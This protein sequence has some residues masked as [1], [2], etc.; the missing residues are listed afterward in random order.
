MLKLI[1]TL[2]CGLV[3]S[4]PFWTWGQQNLVRNSSFEK[5]TRSPLPEYNGQLE[6]K[7]DRWKGFAGT[8]SDWFKNPGLFSGAE[9][10][11]LTAGAPGDPSNSSDPGAP[12]IPPNSGRAYAGLIKWNSTFGEGVQQRLSRKLDPGPHALSFFYFLPCDTNSYGIRAYLGASENDTSFLIVQDTLDRN[13]TGSWIQFSTNFSLSPSQTDFDWLSIVNTGESNPSGGLG[14][15]IYLDDIFL[16][17]SNCTACDPQGLISYNQNVPTTFS[18]DGDGIYDTLYVENINNVS[19]Y[20]M[21]IFD[22][23]GARLWD[24]S[25]FRPGGFENLILKWDGTDQSSGLPVTADVVQLLVHLENCNSSRDILRTVNVCHPNSF[26]SPLKWDTIPNY[27]APLF[28]MELPPTHYGSLDV[29]GG[30]WYGTHHWFACD[31]IRVGA[32]ESKITPYFWAASTSNL[33]FSASQSIEIVQGDSIEIDPGAVVEFTIEPV[34]C[35]ASV[36]LGGAGTT[37]SEA[38][39]TMPVSSTSLREKTS[40]GQFPGPSR[41]HLFPNPTPGMITINCPNEL[42]GSVT[43]TITNSKGQIIQYSQV[44]S[45][46]TIQLDLSKFPCGIYWLQLETRWGRWN[47]KLILQ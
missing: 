33:E 15:Y 18:P 29:Y 41:F 27:V 47:Q 9:D 6:Q 7:C 23:W 43:I 37:E 32:A 10:C 26:C 4:S 22:R 28:G 12:L 20:R 11:Q 35:C 25:A 45:E 16:G 30:P 44:P 38:H 13:Q 17:E 2:A 24:E 5:P 42:A 8:S 21:E 3:L 1:Y 36:R 34:A 39:E 31:S 40:P 46:N 14:S 19:Y